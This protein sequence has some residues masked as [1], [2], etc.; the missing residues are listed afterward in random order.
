MEKVLLYSNTERGLKPGLTIEDQ[1]RYS[2]I[3]ITAVIFSGSLIAILIPPVE[4]Q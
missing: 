2:K 1:M 3:V 4:A